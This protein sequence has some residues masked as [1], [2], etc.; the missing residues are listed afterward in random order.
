MGVN[1]Y[2]SPPLKELV[3]KKIMD[4]TW[5]GA[6]RDRFLGKGQVMEF[7]RHVI[8]LCF[9]C[10]ADKNLDPKLWK[11][12]FS[13]LEEP[14]L[15]PNLELK[16]QALLGQVLLLLKMEMPSIDTAKFNGIIEGL[17]FVNQRHNRIFV[18]TQFSEYCVGVLRKH[19]FDYM[20]L[21]A[22]TA[23][24]K[25]HIKQENHVGLCLD[26]SHFVSNFKLHKGEVAVLLRIFPYLNYTVHIFDKV[27]F[28]EVIKK[29][30]GE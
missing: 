30:R 12:L 29:N 18:D 3:Y 6:I 9:Y 13:Y 16:P 1:G 4:P 15:I 28:L 22:Y 2:S 26:E 19:Y 25:V 7:Y 23:I 21:D 11:E 17:L 8:R 24:A 5:L 27:S 20:H 14:S 10:M